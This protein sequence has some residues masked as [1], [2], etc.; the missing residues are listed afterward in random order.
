[1]ARIMRRI[2]SAVMFSIGMLVPLS[3][4]AESVVHIYPIPT[5][6]ATS[7]DFSV[8]VRPVGGR[9]QRLDCYGVDVNMR[10]PSRASMAYFDFTGTV[11]VAIRFNWGKIRAARVRPLSYGIEPVVKDRTI[12]FSLSRPRN[13]SIE[14]NGDLFHNLHLFAGAPDSATPSLSDPNLIFFGPGFHTPAAEVRLK[15]GQTVYLAPGAVVNTS[16]ICDHVKNVRIAGHGVLYHSKDAVRIDYSDHIVVEGITVM[17]PEHYSV[18]AGNATNVIIRDLKSFSSK[19]WGDGIDLF[20][21]K[22]VRV[23]DVFMRN[24]DDT[25][26]IY[27]HRWGYFGDSSHIQVVN[28]T[29]WP[30]V[31]H[32][33]L[34]GTHGDSHQPEV[35]EDLVFHNIDVLEQNEPQIDYQGCLA[36]NA[37]DGN[38]I[39]HVRVDE[40]RIEDITRGQ[41]LNFRVTFNRKYAEGPGR[42]IEDVYIKDLTYSGSRANMS[43]ISGYDETHAVRD[44]TFENLKINGLV[45]SDHMQEKPSYY[46]TGDVANIFTG[47]HVEG[48]TFRTSVE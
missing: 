41:L 38:L 4:A 24:S 46:K 23:E 25:I 1:M 20:T 10:K 48:L 36:L 19:G 31:A 44:I 7:K 5:G 15:D 13:I 33:I 39:R 42:G 3:A 30:D 32:P 8:S 21:S 11:E 12:R 28:A 14:V 16:L 43:V 29:L 22:N 47:D 34:I 35:I 27:G 45:I 6:I 2:V 17:N 37:S 40:M 9:W 18:L 26:A